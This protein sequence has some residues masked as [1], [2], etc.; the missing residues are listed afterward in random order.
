MP[1]LSRYKHT[2]SNNFSD[3]NH[4]ILCLISIF[5]SQNVWLLYIALWE[6]FT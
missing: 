3:E 4:Q 6:E 5:P 2:L 1:H